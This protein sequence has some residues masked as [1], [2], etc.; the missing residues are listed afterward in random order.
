[1]SVAPA[2]LR[3]DQIGIV[4]EDLE[5]AMGR[6]SWIFG[7]GPWSV[8][9]YGPAVLAESTFRGEPGRYEMRIALAGSGP[10]LELVEPVRGPS[11]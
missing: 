9:T 6:Y 8:Y 3:P 2:G 1:V 7:C 11:I 5:S 10:Q 4:V